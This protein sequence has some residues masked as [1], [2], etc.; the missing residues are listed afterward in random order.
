QRRRVLPCLLQP[1]GSGGGGHDLEARLSVLLCLLEVEAERLEQRDVVVDEE[2]GLHGQAAL[3][4]SS[5]KK[6]PRA[7]GA[8]AGADTS[9]PCRCNPRRSAARESP[10]P[11]ASRDPN[12]SKTRDWSPGSSAECSSSSS[13]STPRSEGR[14]VRS[15]GSPSS[16]LEATFRSS[17]A[18]TGRSRIPSERTRGK[19]SPPRSSRRMLRSARSC[20][21]S[22]PDSW[23]S[24]GNDQV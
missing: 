9:P 6:T 24:S 14:S 7:G 2:E 18:S 20:S 13:T 4:K 16:R 1:G 11:R 12:G 3:A 10:A 5:R 22:P 23:I 21:M 19:P 15:N 8:A 17:W